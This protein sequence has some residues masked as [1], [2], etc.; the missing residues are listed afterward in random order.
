MKNVLKKAVIIMIAAVAMSVS[1]VAQQQ[2]DKAVGGNLI[3]STYSSHG[4]SYNRVGIGAKFF[5]NVTN[6]IR[7]AGEFDYF[8]KKDNVTGWDISA[9]GHYIFQVADQIW[10][11]PSAGIGVAGG[12][13]SYGGYSNTNNDLAISLGGGA[14]YE[15]ASNLH[16]N[17]ELRLKL[18][19][20]TNHFN[21]VIGLAYKF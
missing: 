10:V 20:G 18:I 14:D 6:P 16:L 19:D 1:A 9:Y 21:I 5:Y 12:K 15:L 7:L 13:Y 4:Q 11:Y 17:T 3:I 8:L 2:G